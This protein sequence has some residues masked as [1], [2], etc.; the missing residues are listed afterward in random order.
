MQKQFTQ[1]ELGGFY[2]S[3]SVAKVHEFAVN[4]RLILY[5]QT[6]RIKNANLI[7]PI[8]TVTVYSHFHNLLIIK[9]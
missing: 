9:R 5:Y 4:T 3:L 8:D 1:Q 7:T 2:G 6:L